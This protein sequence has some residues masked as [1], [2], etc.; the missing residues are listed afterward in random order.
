MKAQSLWRE[1]WRWVLL[2]L[3]GAWV[4]LIAASYYAGLHEAEE[5]TDAHLAAAVNV[6]L[7]VNAFGVRDPMTEPSDPTADQGLQSFVP[8]GRKLD[9]T[10]SLAVVV[11][12]RDAI[13]ADSRPLQQRWPIPVTEGY[14]T[15][16]APTAGGRQHQWRMFVAQRDGGTRRAAA[17][18]NQDQRQRVGRI[19]ALTIA[20]PALLVLPLVA[21]L[22]WWA[23][24]RGL[25]PLQ[26]LSQRVAA[27][28]LGSG[29]RLDG[30]ERFVEFQSVVGAINGLI[31]QVQAQLAHERAFASDLAHE[32]R[33]PLAAVALQ[34]QIA[35]QANEPA[36]RGE[37]LA[38][39]GRESLRAGRVL[40][41]LLALARAR[42]DDVAAVALLPL[43][44]VAARAMAAFAQASHDS[45]HVLELD[46]GAADAP[47]EVRGN[48]VLLELA[49]SNLIANA[50]RHTPSG[51]QVRVA[52]G[53]S[54][55][56]MP[57]L[58]VS[59]DGSRPGSEAVPTAHGDGL[60][61]GLRLVERIARLHH[62]RLVR[63]AAETPMTTCYALRWDRVDGG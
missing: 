39:V 28:D 9:L 60:G 15:F 50:L 43:A 3:A 33:T 34:A 12:E 59:D 57:W 10:R 36:A 61:W 44:D 19:V 49:I 25:R 29:A 5:I 53:R 27:L 56:G 22:L 55:D 18:I 54:P 30:V 62:A 17:L 2:A 42:R 63:E 35:A 26:V 46:A 20:R 45:G 11:W 21:L 58:K 31:D 48:A 24:R 4:A 41:E 1:I 40:S 16:S 51:T 7:Q 6:M 38:R 52:L 37:A 47:V 14:S 23:L 13:V 8:L 32:L